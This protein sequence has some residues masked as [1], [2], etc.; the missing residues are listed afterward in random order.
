M[1]V[2]FEHHDVSTVG[3]KLAKQV[4]RRKSRIAARQQDEARMKRPRLNDEGIRQEKTSSPFGSPQN[5]IGCS[6]GNS[7]SGGAS[8][9]SIS[10]N[11]IAPARNKGGRPRTKPLDLVPST[12]CLQKGTVLRVNRLVQAQIPMDVWLNIFSYAKPDFLFKARFVCKSFNE[13]LLKE[14]AWKQALLQQFGPSLPQPP[15]GLSQMN[16]ANLLTQYGCQSCRDEGKGSTR[17]TYWAFQ[18]RYCETCLVDK[19]VFV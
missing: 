7:A 2:S 17:R 19:I 18:R 10:C 13:A 14:S 8:T 5:L 12:K 3:A 1:E 6:S 11:M 9:F 15:A 4:Q 16:Y